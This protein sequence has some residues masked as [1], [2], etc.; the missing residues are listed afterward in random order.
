NRRY[1]DS[2]LAK[3]LTRAEREGYSVGVIMI[4]VDHFKQY[5][6]IYGHDA[7]DFV[8]KTISHLLIANVRHA[9]IACRYGGEEMT[10]IL[11]NAS[12]TDAEK[13]AEEIRVSLSQLILNYQ[14]QSLKQLTASF[15]VA[16]FPQHGERC[17]TLLQSADA[18]LYQAKAEGRNRVIVADHH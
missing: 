4:D 3:E 9:D 6:D 12:L 17:S 13:R 10:L 14:K 1:L 2:F 8:L 18:A 5:N 7:G 16:V 11:P 15:G